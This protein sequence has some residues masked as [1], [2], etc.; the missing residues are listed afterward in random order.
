MENIAETIRLIAK[1]KELDEEILFESIQAALITAFKK[2]FGNERQS[3]VTIDRETGEIHIYSQYNVVEEVE[4]EDVEM[5]LE[6][7]KT[8]NK[9]Y[10]VGDTLEIEETPKDFGRIS[11]LAAKQ[12]VV[13]RIR[14]AERNSILDEYRDREKEIIN[15]VIQRINNG[16]VYFDLGKSEALLLPK[17]QVRGERYKLGSRYRTLITEVKSTTKGPQ[18][19]VSRTHPDLVKRLFELEVPE[20]VEGDVIIKSIAR[21]AGSRTKIAVESQVENLDPVGT[22]V[23]QKGARVNSIVDELGGEK[24]DIIE[25]VDDPL[26]YIENA[27]SPSKVVSVELNEKDARVIVPDYQLSLAIG[28]EGQNARL[29]AKLTGY[30]IDILSE[31]QAE[32]QEEDEA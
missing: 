5:S 16:V 23:G 6:D 4:N 17:E 24:I 22:C 25:Y 20:I 3:R 14:E 18:I 8:Y 31:T 11:A 27:L 12:V 21:E 26:K 7:A 30:K 19:L 1:E 13:Q 28:K 9:S 15:G 10:E 32:E 2:H 29:A